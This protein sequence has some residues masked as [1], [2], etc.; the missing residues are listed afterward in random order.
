[1]DEFTLTYKT[2]VTDEQS[3][4]HFYAM[5]HRKQTKIINHFIPKIFAVLKKDMLAVV[6]AVKKHGHEYAK[7]HIDTI[8]KIEPMIPVIKSIYLKSAYVESNFVLNYLRR[9]KK[10]HTGG[11]TTKR[12]GSESAGF[13]LG[14]DDLAPVID[15]YFKIRLLNDSAI[16]INATTKKFVLRHLIRE[17]DNGKDYNTAIKDFM[18][19]AI[20][21]LMPKAKTRARRIAIAEST[22][23]L[24]F[25]GLIGAYMSGVDVDKIWVTSDDERVRGWPNYYAKYPHV[26]LDLN[27][28]SIFGS[29]YNGEKIKFPG[30]PDAD[31]LNTA[32][33]RC[34]MYFKAKREPNPEEDFV[35]PDIV[36]LGT[37]AKPRKRSL[38]NFLTDFLA[39]I[40]SFFTN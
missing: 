36:G 10:S 37:P 25:G 35:N 2:R 9:R 13:G 33:C 1:M 3:A 15:S 31:I 22:K 21:G 14:F 4:R 11:L 30:D 16:P 23:A 32:G 34:A 18:E 19:L 38:A 12:L 27:A 20:D 7:R 29:F 24:S 8:I 40:I 5:H 17:I 26:D 39:G 28:S 6:D